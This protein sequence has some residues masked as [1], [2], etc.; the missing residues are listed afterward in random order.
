MKI[1]L[2]IVSLFASIKLEMLKCG[3]EE[4]ENC[5]QCGEGENSGTC[6]KCK[7]KHFLFFHNLYCFP[8]DHI[9]YGQE[10]C[11]GN[12]NGTSFLENRQVYCN[13]YECKIGFYNENGICKN[14]TDESPYCS[15]CNMTEGMNEDGTKNYSNFVC[16]ACESNEFLLKDNSCQP[17]YISHCSKCHFNKIVEECDI[18]DD[19][20]FLNDSQ[21]ISCYNKIDNGYCVC[22]NNNKD[23]ITCTCDYSYYLNETSMCAKCPDNCRYCNFSKINNQVECK[24]CEN[25]YAL[26]PKNECISCGDD[27]ENCIIDK[28]SEITCTKCKND[29]FLYENQ[30]LTCP[31]YCSECKNEKNQIKCTKCF[32]NTILH[33]NGTCIFCDGCNA[34]ECFI[35]DDGEQ[36]CKSCKYGYYFLS[37]E[38]KCVKC[39]DLDPIRGKGCSECELNDTTKKY[40]CKVCSNGYI[41]IINEGICEANNKMNL[42]SSCD[43]AE[44]KGDLENPIYSCTKCLSDSVKIISP[45]N[46]S[47]CFGI[48]EDLAFCSEG[49][50]DDKEAKN[51][52]KCVENAHF[53]KNRLCECDSDSFY[54]NYPNWYSSISKCYKCDS[55]YGNIGCEASKG[56]Q[57]N[58]SNNQ[59]ICNQCK[60]DFYE[61]GKGKCYSCS[62]KKEF[63]NKCKIDYTKEE[64][65]EFKC[66]GCLGSFVYNN[67]E[68]YCELFYEECPQIALG[69]YVFNDEYKSK[70][71]CHYCKPGYF[72][73][74]D[75]S[76]I[77][78]RAEEYGGP[79]CDK[80]GYTIDEKGKET[81]DIKCE[82]CKGINKAMSS[83]GKCVNCKNK[84]SDKCERCKFV[85]NGK[86]EEL[87]CTLCKTGYYLD[88]N[89]NCIS[90]L[91]YIEKISNCYEMSFNIGNLSCTYDIYSNYIYCKIPDYYD[92]YY[93]SNNSD[94][95]V[96][97]INE[98]LKGVK[99]P[100]KGT[101]QACEYGY[102]L[103]DKNLCVEVK[104]EDCT[105][106]SIIQ[107]KEK[108]LYE[109]KNYCNDKHFALTIIEMENTN[110]DIDST[111]DNKII[112]NTLENLVEN[113]YN[114]S[115]SLLEITFCIDN[116]G[117][118]GNKSPE[119]LQ[120]CHIAKYIEKENKFIC[121]KCLY[122]YILDNSTN[123]C[124]KEKELNRND[125]CELENIGTE[126]NP[127]YS[128]KICNREQNSYYSSYFYIYNQIRDYY[129]NKYFIFNESDYYYSYYTMVK[130]GN[131]NICIWKYELEEN[132]CLNA[133]VNT[134]YLTYKY[135]C[136]NCTSYSYLPYNSRYYE[137]RICQDIYEDI[138]KEKNLSNSSLN[139]FNRTESA[140]SLNESCEK[141]YLFTPDG[142]HCYLCNDEVVGIPGCKGACSFSLKRYNSLK[143]ESK[144]DTGYLEYREGICELCDQINRGCY[145][146]HYENKFPEN[147]VGIKTKR[148]FV[149]DF[150]E[151]GYYLENGTCH[152]CS[153]N[154]AKCDINSK[155][156]VVCEK[157]ENNYYLVNGSCFYC[158]IYEF[159]NNGKC[160]SCS[161]D[162]N[163]GIK[164]C[165][166]CEKNEDKVICRMCEDD[167]ILLTNNNTCLKR[168]S[169]KEIEQF[170]NCNQLTFDN[171]NK[172]FC[173]RCSDEDYTLLKE[174]DEAKCT[175]I[176]SL[177]DN[178][179]DIA[180][181]TPNNYY[182]TSSPDYINYAYDKYYNEYIKVDLE[183]CQEA[184]N[185]GTKDKPLYT[186]TKCYNLFEY[187]RSD[188]NDYTLYTEEKSNLSYCIWSPY[189]FDN[190]IH[191]IRKNN[192]R[193]SE[194][195]CI[196]CDKN[197]VFVF[198][199]EKNISYC[200]PLDLSEKCNV[201]YCKE[202]QPGKNYICKSPISEDYVINQLTGSCGKKTA[203]IPAI[204][205][206]DIYRLKMNSFKKIN[207]RMYYG[208]YFRIRG[209]T[210][211]EINIGHLFL[212][213]ITI[214]N[215]IKKNIRNL[216]QEPIKI[217]AICKNIYS[218]EKDDDYAHI[219]DYECIGDANISENLD[220]YEIIKIEDV[221]NI[222]LKKSNLKDLSLVGLSNKNQ[223][224]FTL[225]DLMKVI[226]FKMDDIKNFTTEDYYFDFKIDGKLFNGSINP[227]EINQ[228]MD[229]SESNDGL[230]ANCS[231]KVEEN[232]TAYLKC[233]LNISE[234]KKQ[235]Y[236][237]FKTSE[238]SDKNNDIFILNL[239]Q[240]KLINLLGEDPSDSNNTNESNEDLNNTQI[241][242]FY[243]ST[244]RS[245]KKALAIGLSISV[246]A[247]A[248]AAFIALFLFLNGKSANNAV[249]TTSNVVESPSKDLI[250]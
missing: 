187:D 59:F 65:E 79:A 177:Y 148:R 18:C 32:G 70:N 10:G 140:S 123:L 80:C 165:S 95:Y 226:I 84:L 11:G 41:K 23:N 142:K 83:D 196:K 192:G 186:C 88:S 110:K 109:C 159:L 173:S 218:L 85:K 141:D 153:M 236:F 135:N 91:D 238:I 222:N 176:P 184:I 247:V 191:A 168:S 207:G 111:I 108:L 3:E 136:T 195:S 134:T 27:C 199:S 178:N 183:P 213:Y 73:T 227:C 40:D 106:S 203:I 190:C 26:N 33:P 167:Y 89:N 208:P 179:D 129:Y 5:E 35:N 30:C 132:N 233:N 119:N 39:E 103:N 242:R 158:G 230:A 31:N 55:N 151:N 234:Y 69:C 64:K 243:R 144:C 147:Y 47:N 193:K 14:C 235:K 107:N 209:I 223:S 77:F 181:I 48:S 150:C 161:D 164:E 152:K 58:T 61:Y 15:N 24:I 57:Y 171:N 182:N 28:N 56:C 225:D 215:K 205:W 37:S 43:E 96:N 97:Y 68:K 13:S 241:N 51:C 38:N 44:N 50:I 197:S 7:D 160:I 224:D 185:I 94:I 22:H 170:K 166:Y 221:D 102:Y 20:F 214:L 82:I 98:N 63:C 133:T 149:C 189:K 232:K 154:C 228:M 126:A 49:V 172:L 4:I 237:S 17:C 131:V 124:K 66:E 239:D 9:Y 146:C 1:L 120:N 100:I 81:N 53:N 72:K 248:V 116:K 87:K 42:S 2:I 169:N 99:S 113:N 90:F 16:Q 188:K 36:A 75:E 122:G 249:I 29:K 202:C 86:T 206:K 46:L 105:L 127:I 121:Y 60:E 130:E 210:N 12:C 67:D 21:C 201:K 217:P 229:I 211:S 45:K 117:T 54:N 71:K 76:C 125:N 212:I 62:E 78:C 145:E 114:K 216:E 8:C 200:E 231:F 112:L 240:V 52:T 115:K 220:N 246:V 219:I 128:C 139:D 19:Y 137:K 92:D 101:C 143:C 6:V 157:C 156:E 155:N 93:N 104:L 194:F 204:T 74:K 162:K 25:N 198:D 118:G 163:G 175:S 245:S 180:I 174:D 244:K 34:E 250:I 138:I